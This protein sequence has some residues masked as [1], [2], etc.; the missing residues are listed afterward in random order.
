MEAL[1]KFKNGDKTNVNILRNGHV[2]LVE[3]QF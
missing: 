1:G 2:M 3:I